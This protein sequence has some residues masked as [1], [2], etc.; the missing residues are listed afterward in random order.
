M[1]RQELSSECR[2]GCGRVYFQRSPLA[3]MMMRKKE[4]EKEKDGR[5][6]GKEGKTGLQR[7]NEWEAGRPENWKTGQLKNRGIQK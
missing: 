5:M 1:L 3:M 6:A 7:N 4:G 2:L